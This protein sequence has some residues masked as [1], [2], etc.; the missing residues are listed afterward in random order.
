MAYVD[1]IVAGDPA[2]ARATAEQA[3]T[4]RKFRITWNDDWTA[5]AERGSM[6]GNI[7]AGAF[8]QYF[9]IGVQLRSLQ[10]GETVIRIESQSSGLAG[11]AIGMARTKSNFASL[12]IGL[13][14]TFGSA[15]VLLGVQEGS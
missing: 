11:G 3:L 1:F 10:P 5:T 2:I 9:K 4:S 7:L 8:A 13:E 15:G 12:R 14:A 6:I